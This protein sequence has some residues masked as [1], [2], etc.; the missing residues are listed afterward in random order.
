MKTL[1]KQH[2]RFL[3]DFEGFLKDFWTHKNGR[4]TFKWQYESFFIYSFILFHL[5]SSIRH[6]N[7][8]FYQDSISVLRWVL[9]HKL[10]MHKVRISL[11][12]VTMTDWISHPLSWEYNVYVRS[13]FFT[14]QIHLL[15]R[16]SRPKFVNLHHLP[17]KQVLAPRLSY[18]YWDSKIL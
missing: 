18:V 10:E 2:C 16:I 5:S 17:W 7:S 9:F 8:V 3:K 14:H 13:L 4:L 11:R 1:Y 15:S 12:P 6:I